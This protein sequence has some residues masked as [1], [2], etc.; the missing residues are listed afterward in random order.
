[1]TSNLKL[2]SPI[3]SSNSGRE[4]GGYFQ[5]LNVSGG[6]AVV[7]TQIQ[8][9]PHLYSGVKYRFLVRNFSCQFVCGGH[10]LVSIKVIILQILNNKRKGKNMI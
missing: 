5:E 2:K 8:E 1:M 6:G 7:Y 9:R 3:R 4:R 10:K